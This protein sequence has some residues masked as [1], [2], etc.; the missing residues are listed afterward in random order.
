MYAGVASLLEQMSES[1][2]HENGIIEWACP[3]PF[4]GDPGTAKVATVGL[5]PS[6]NEF[7]CSSGFELRAGLQRL[8][9]LRSLKLR[10][11]KEASTAD[12]RRI[13]KACRQYFLGNPYNRWFGVLERLLAPG[14]TSFY[15]HRPSAFHIDVVPWATEQKWG[16]LT[17]QNRRG[18]LARCDRNLAQ[19]LQDAQ[20]LELIVLNGSSTVRHFESLSGHRLAGSVVDEWALRRSSGTDIP[21]VSYSTTI[22]TIGSYALG[23]PLRVVGFNHNLQSSYGVTRQVLESIALWVAE[24]TARA[25]RY[26]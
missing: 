25:R 21:G 15:G 17:T 24:Q 4:F 22:D 18:I 1:D 3:V 23:R 26:A 20:A 6:N 10:N 13:L 8:P 14:G 12:T 2:L 7:V 19:V 5:N 11:W 9:T 16:N